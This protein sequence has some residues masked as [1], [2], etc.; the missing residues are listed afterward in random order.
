MVFEANLPDNELG[1]L[2]SLN[3]DFGA[4]GGSLT[5]DL[6]LEGT[7]APFTAGGET[8]TYSV[9]DDG[10]IL[11]AASAS[12]TVLTIELGAPEDDR[13][14]AEL[15]RPIDHVGG[16]DDLFQLVLDL[17]ATD[18]DGDF[19]TVTDGLR[20]FIVD[21]EPTVDVEGAGG[22]LTLDRL[23][24]TPADSFVPGDD[25]AGD[26]EPATA[27]AI[28]TVITDDDAVADLFLDDQIDSGADEPASVETVYSLILR[29]GAGAAVGTGSPVATALFGLGDGDGIREFP[30]ELVFLVQVS[31]TVIEGRVG[32]VG[33]AAV[34]RITLDLTE[35]DNPLLQ[36]D[37]LGPLDHPVSGDGPLADHDDAAILE[38]LNATVDTAGISV[39][40][41]TTVTDFDGDSAT[42]SAEVN[43]TA[44]IVIEDDGPSA[45][46][47]TG[48]VDE[49][50]LPGGLEGGPGDIDGGA[51]TVTD[52]AT[53]T[54]PF[55]FGRDGA[56]GI[57][58]AAMDGLNGQ[59][60]AGS[61]TTVD[62]SWNGA[63]T[64]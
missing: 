52:V 4:D 51:G 57:D 45:G 32:G 30:S 25:N 8:V 27:G 48:S 19:I 55:D 21:D 41:T 43:I 18:G 44:Q 42:D 6:A 36:V 53:G 58:F 62:Y 23:D 50:L 10:Q 64:P 1:F 46:A 35:P 33:G 3:L 29:D 22:V 49:D 24:E 12:G 11:T 15:L 14:T 2:G 13:F 38:L 59:A 47:L 26:D 63:A 40:K 61:S 7:T 28:G 60:I 54:L 31:D 56:G 20:L 16:S 5:F 9:S 37:Q 39:V 34:L 17:R